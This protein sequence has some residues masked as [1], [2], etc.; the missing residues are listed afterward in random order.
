MNKIEVLKKRRPKDFLEECGGN[1]IEAFGKFL[2]ASEN[3]KAELPTLL[4]LSKAP[5]YNKTFR[6]D[7]GEYVG[8]RFVYSDYE[9]IWGVYAD[10]YNYLKKILYTL[11]KTIARHPEFSDC[12]IVLVENEPLLHMDSAGTGYNYHALYILWNSTG[13][14]AK[15]WERTQKIQAILRK[16][17]K[18]FMFGRDRFDL[19]YESFFTADE[20]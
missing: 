16:Y 20:E 14:I 17:Q 3:R 6:Y 4:S 12:R 15:D 1:K 9:E 2:E 11:R 8:C 7:G 19:Q 13:D 5:Q 18:V 10:S